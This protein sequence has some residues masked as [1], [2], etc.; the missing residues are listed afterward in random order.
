MLGHRIGT[1]LGVS[2]KTG[3]S[4]YQVHVVIER[5]R[6]LEIIHEDRRRGA[7]FVVRDPYRLLDALA[8]DRPLVELSA[9]SLRPE[10]GS[11]ADAERL[12]RTVARKTKADYAFT[13]FAGLSKYLEYYLSYP[14]IHVYSGKSESLMRAIPEGRGPVTTFF[15]QPDSNAVLSGIR[16]VGGCSVVDPIQVVID[17]YCLG[18]EG[19]D[20][21]IKLYEVLE[22]K[23]VKRDKWRVT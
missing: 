12:I 21:A 6:S 18:D 23:D 4:L 22:R 19:R 2:E 9:G 13:C 3:V 20:G 8:F 1:Q 10:V 7:R 15:L 14:A 16:E 17:L 11:L 5:L